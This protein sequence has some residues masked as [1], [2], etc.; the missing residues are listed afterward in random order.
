MKI[1]NICSAKFN[2]LIKKT[3]LIQMCGS[4]STVVKL[5]NCIQNFLY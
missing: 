1:F 5:I 3:N 2:K 4:Q